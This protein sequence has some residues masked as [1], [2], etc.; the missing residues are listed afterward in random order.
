MSLTDL[1]AL[2]PALVLVG[3]IVGAI[4]AV[5]GTFL[6]QRNLWSLDVLKDARAL[7]D[8]KRERLRKNYEA[9]LLSLSEWLGDGEAS[10]K[11]NSLAVLERTY[12]QLLLEPEAEPVVRLLVVLVDN[13]ERAKPWFSDMLDPDTGHTA[14]ELGRDLVRDLRRAMEESLTAL[15]KPVRHIA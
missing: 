13:P 8:A 2:A 10:S 7:R 12:L 1:T 6:T 5:G 4:A 9:A 11:A 15:E 14:K 3:T